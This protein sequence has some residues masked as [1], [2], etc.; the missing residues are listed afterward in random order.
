MTLLRYNICILWANI[1][2]EGFVCVK[3]GFQSNFES[4][5]SEYTTKEVLCAE[6]DL[7]RGGKPFKDLQWFLKKQSNCSKLGN[8]IS[9]YK[10]LSI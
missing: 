5:H 10:E 6:L 3:Q 1:C 4:S 9:F 7:I 2:D 8:P